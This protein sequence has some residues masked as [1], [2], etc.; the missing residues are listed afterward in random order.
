MS[1]AILRPALLGRHRGED[2]AV[3]PCRARGAQAHELG[4]VLGEEVVDGDDV[5]ALAGQGVE[6][7]RE[8]RDEGLALTGLHLCDVAH[9]QG[10][11]THDLH[12]EVP[13]AEGPLARLPDGGEGL[14]EEH[15]E[16]LALVEALA[17]ARGL[18]AQFLVGELLEVGLEGVDLLGDA[19]EPLDRVR[20]SPA[21]SSFSMTAIW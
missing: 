15:V 20:P 11:A 14:G 17:E 5:D 1:L 8:G 7:A 21:R 10:R 2:A 6:V 16:R 9:V 12:V 19:L 13:L 3:A 18:V 4:L